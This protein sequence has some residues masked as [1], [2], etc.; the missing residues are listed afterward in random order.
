M[1]TEFLELDEDPAAL[2]AVEDRVTEL[3]DGLIRDAPSQNPGEGVRNRFRSPPLAS[4]E[5]LAGLAG[6]FC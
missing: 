5:E 4:K 1:K 2:A 3:L 6:S